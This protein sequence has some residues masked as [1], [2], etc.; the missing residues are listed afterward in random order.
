[1]ILGVAIGQSDAQLSVWLESTDAGFDFHGVVPLRA[2][3]DL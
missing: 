3:V 1:L 2:F